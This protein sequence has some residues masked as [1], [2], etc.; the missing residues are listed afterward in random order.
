LKS[1]EDEMAET[2]VKG[3]ITRL[4]FKSPTFSTGELESPEDT[5]HGRLFKFAGSVYAGV[6]DEVILEGKWVNDPKWGWQFKVAGFQYDASPT[7]DGLITFLAKDKRFK[8]IGEARAKKIVEGIESL[9]DDF[10]SVLQEVPEDQI[11]IAAGLQPQLVATLKK[12]WFERVEMNR[13]MAEL[14][15]YDVTPGQAQRLFE[16]FGPS[17]IAIVQRDPYWL[18]GKV[19]GF[20]FKTVD[21]IALRTGI[22]HN[23]PSRLRE[24]IYW[25]LS[26]AANR[27][28]HTHVTKGELIHDAVELLQL[29]RDD[30]MESFVGVAKDLIS[31]GDLIQAK[32]SDGGVGIWDARMHACEREVAQIITTN[33]QRR[34]HVLFREGADRRQEWTREDIETEFPDLVRKQAMAVKAAAN[35]HLSVMSGGAGV[36]KTYT[37]D[38]ICRL[39]EMHGVDNIALCA[40]T[41]KAAKRMEESMSRPAQTMH[42]LLG[43]KFEKDSDG[44]ARFTFQ[45]GPGNP[46]TAEL[47]V[48]DEVS[49]VDVRLFRHFFSA[50]DFDKTAV[51]LVGDHNQLPPVGPG[52]VLRDLVKKETLCPIT[53]LDEV[54]RQAGELKENVMAVLGGEISRGHAKAESNG[55]PL[56]PWYVVNNFVAP[57]QIAGFVEYLVAHRFA[58]YTREVMG[59][60]G[61][62]ERPIDPIW[63]V[64][65]LTPMHKGDIG[66][67]A[68]NRA[69]QRIHQARY[70]VE[71][72]PPK[73]ENERHKILLHD[74]VICTKNNYRVN[75]MNGAMGRVV[76]VSPEDNEVVVDFEGSGEKTMKGEDV[77]DLELAYAMTVHK[78]Q[79]SEYPVVV[80]VCSKA[81]YIMHHRGLLYTAVSRA[82]QCAMIV[83]DNTAIHNCAKKVKTDRRRTMMGL[84]DADFTEAMNTQNLEA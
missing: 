60:D 54:H 48:V 31:K 1:E 59:P 52:A 64:Q 61:L 19:R 4:F 50:I 39:F 13:V 28:G 11:A 2:Q 14:A 43:P 23:H 63:D 32:L 62:E 53:I 40:P 69:I 15:V 79:G 41:G 27:E 76:G 22:A 25:L 42:M 9:G 16:D 46:L 75:V 20:G 65:F 77:F 66:T 70:G 7:R 51:V 82:R 37:V 67:K 10:E 45:H 71:V 47:I 3:Q 24:G 68:L 34:H 12:V 56:S 84:P 81:H 74:K 80:V 21:A 72:P 78:S 49:M 6:G 57:S 73:R 44:V 5:D 55:G 35:W 26:E 18:I 29:E 58:Q 36:G 17:V 83:G 8:G 30:D 33:G 38:A